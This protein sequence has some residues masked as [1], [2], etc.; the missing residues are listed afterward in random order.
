MFA[1]RLATIDDAEAISRLT[2]D[3]QRLH[4]QAVPDIFKPASDQLFPVMKL[5]TLVANPDCVVAV[6]EADGKV[7]GHIYGAVV[8]RGENEFTKAEA[9][10]YIQQVGIEE[11]ERRL[12]IGTALVNFVLDRARAMGL[13]AVQV[14][15]WAFNTRAESF[16]AACGFAPMK[17]VRRRVLKDT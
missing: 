10:M 17:V 11:S 8:R 3:V 14:D 1:I 9:H 6:A 16:F 15:H 4:N 13:A 7:I 5:A 12:G 2:C